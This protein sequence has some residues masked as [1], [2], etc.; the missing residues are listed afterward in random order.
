[1]FPLLLIGF[2]SI[3][4][5]KIGWSIVF[6]MLILVI[7]VFVSNRISKRNGDIVSEINKSKDKRVQ[8]TTEVIEGIKYVKLYGWE[9]A[10]KKIILNIRSV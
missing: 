5:T 3:M 1:M 2:Y 8:I 4:A 6:G 10:F 9:L 7:Y